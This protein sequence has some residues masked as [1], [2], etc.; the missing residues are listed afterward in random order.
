MRLYKTLNLGRNGGGM[1]MVIW[2][3]V[4]IRRAGLALASL[5]HWIDADPALENGKAPDFRGFSVAASGS[6][7]R[8]L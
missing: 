1:R 6:P 4:K 7:Q 8:D 3:A 2:S 5:Q